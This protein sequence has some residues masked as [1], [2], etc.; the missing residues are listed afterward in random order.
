MKQPTREGLSEHLLDEIVSGR[1]A[2]GTK[3]SPE[4]V[5]AH[6]FGLSRPV[7]REVLR[8]LQ[9]KGLVDILPA[10]GT[11]VREP[12]TIDGARS[13]ES[14]YRRRNATAREVM[15][16]RLMTETHTARLAAARATA[17]DVEVLQRCLTDCETAD[18]VIDRARYDIAFHGLL[19]RASHNT[20]I[21]TMFGSIA[22]LTF[23]LMLRSHADPQVMSQ[24]LPYHRSILEAVQAGDPD[25]AER[26]MRDH[27]GLA[28]TLY[29]DDYDRS[30]EHVARRE[31]Q[32]FLRGP[33]TLEG[34]LDEV[35]RRFDAATD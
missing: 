32:R 19:A 22:S 24:G 16:S 30:V 25:R 8:G 14:Y 5:L 12:S 6:E 33:M 26:A 20:V 17:A 11:F 29:G 7:V 31:F 4:R 3:L 28:G 23:E 2:P 15:E 1:L 18:N 27:L 9:E 21:E 34:L 13:L 35:V 10:R